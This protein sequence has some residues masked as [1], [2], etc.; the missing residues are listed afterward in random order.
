MNIKARLE[1]LEAHR[2]EIELK[3]IF[4]TVIGREVTRATTGGR[5]WKRSD[6]ES[7]ADFTA[8]IGNGLKNCGRKIVVVRL[9]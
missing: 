4:V 6:G 1:R 5:E 3:V 2:S 8:R 7:R 9:R